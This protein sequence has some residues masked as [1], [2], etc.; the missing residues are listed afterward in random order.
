M[1]LPEKLFDQL[2]VPLAVFEEVTRVD[3]PFA[4]DLEAFLDSRIK[5]VKNKMAVEMLSENSL[6]FGSLKKYRYY[7]EKESL[8]PGTRRMEK[9]FSVNFAAL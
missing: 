1:D 7:T 2:F 8:P 9:R 3:K 5:H 6:R 4:K